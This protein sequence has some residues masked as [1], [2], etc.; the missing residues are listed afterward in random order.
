MCRSSA[1]QAQDILYTSLTLSLPYT[2]GVYHS[3]FLGKETKTE[4][5]LIHGPGSLTSFCPTPKPVLLTTRLNGPPSLLL[6]GPGNLS[7]EEVG[8]QLGP[9]SLGQIR[10]L[11]QAQLFSCPDTCFPSQDAFLPVT[12]SPW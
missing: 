4:K 12:L 6:K 5:I 11:A 8:M 10:T 3:S 9:S 2:V 7:Q 1:N